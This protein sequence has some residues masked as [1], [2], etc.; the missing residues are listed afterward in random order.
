MEGLIDKLTGLREEDYCIFDA[1]NSL[2]KHF[3]LCLGL[4]GYHLDILSQFLHF[5]LL[6]HEIFPV[7]HFNLGFILSLLQQGE[8]ITDPLIDGVFLLDELLLFLG[9]HGCGEDG[10]W[11]TRVRTM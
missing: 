6:D 8:I 3:K 2:P 11:P 10:S 5:L 7:E 9:D 1:T 4:L